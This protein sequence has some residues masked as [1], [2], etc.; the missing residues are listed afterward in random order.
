MQKKNKNITITVVI[1]CI[2]I[3]AS[4]LFF[5]NRQQKIYNNEFISKISNI[6]DD[7]IVLGN[8]EAKNTVIMFFDYNCR[9]CRKFMNTVYPDFKKTYLD[10]GNTK[11][12]LRL[13]CS[14]NDSIAIQAYQT[15]V[16]INKFGN[17]EKLHRLLLHKNEI[18]Y[19]E[20]FQELKDEYI[21]VNEFVANCLFNSNN[22]TIKTNIKQFKEL[23][24]KGTP[25]FIINKK[26]LVGYQDINAI[27]KALK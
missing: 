27:T 15:V 8:R 22:S 11:L 1:L 16:C 21:A 10:T 13:T 26:I 5:K 9:Y 4:L 24:T 25:T 18:I 20:Y 17:F 14:P 3:I 2:A 19:S 12:V 7:D 6:N 23:K